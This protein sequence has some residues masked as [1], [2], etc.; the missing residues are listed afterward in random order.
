MA[1]FV[2]E[3][4]PLHLVFYFKNVII[5]RFLKVQMSRDRLP[6]AFNEF[7]RIYLYEFISSDLLI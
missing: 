7:M 3:K 2:Q 5:L 4:L 6:D 1:Q